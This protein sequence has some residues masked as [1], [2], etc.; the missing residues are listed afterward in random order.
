M[1][2]PVR[3][4]RAAIDPLAHEETLGAERK[5]KVRRACGGASRHDAATR[6]SWRA[7]HRRQHA[8]VL[9]VRRAMRRVP[10][11]GFWLDAIAGAW[12]GRP[13]F[14]WRSM[15][16]G[17]SI[18]LGLV[19]AAVW[20]HGQA[21][22]AG[23]T[24]AEE[25]RGLMRELEVDATVQELVKPATARANDALS[26]AEAASA[27][28]ERAAL[29][30]AAALEWAQV[31]RDLKR[32]KLAEQL[33]DRL[34]QELSALQTENVRSRAAVEQAKARVGRARQELLELEAGAPKPAQGTSAPGA[35]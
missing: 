17:S 3:T 12:L 6:R 25:A 29:L 19:S 35:R 10:P 32:A 1:P 27:T 7:K 24:L 4:P 31:A 33:S 11:Q 34:E 5:G 23:G 26:R 13:V 18:A 15:L 2:P 30:E 9:R 16:R 20:L 22:A 21:L 14:R 8:D 28:P